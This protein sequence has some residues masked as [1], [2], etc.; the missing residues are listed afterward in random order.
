MFIELE[1][2]KCGSYIYH[3]WSLVIQQWFIV[4]IT[5]LDSISLMNIHNVFMHCVT[6]RYLFKWSDIIMTL[7]RLNE[8]ACCHNHLNLTTALS[9]ILSPYQPLFMACFTK[10]QLKKFWI[11]CKNVCKTH[12]TR[13]V[14]ICLICILIYLKMGRIMKYVDICITGTKSVWICNGTFAE[15]P[16]LLNS[17]WPSDT[18]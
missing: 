2:Q 12:Q 16:Y 4:C 11:L 10:I 14:L 15:Y 5:C 6:S 1:F 18:I 7:W 13:A 8:I 3:T 9:T 17:L